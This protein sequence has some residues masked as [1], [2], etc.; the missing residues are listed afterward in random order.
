[1]DIKATCKVA[2]LQDLREAVMA[3]EAQGFKDFDLV[4]PPDAWLPP[5]SPATEAV[6][7]KGLGRLAEVMG[8]DKVKRDTGIVLWM[9]R[10]TRPTIRETEE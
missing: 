10:R 8:G 4:C 5:E 6:M 2:T 7:L 3:F 9:R 1:M